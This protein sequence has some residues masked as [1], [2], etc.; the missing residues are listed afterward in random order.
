MG[1]TSQAPSVKNSNGKVRFAALDG[2]ADSKLEENIDD[3]GS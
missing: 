1:L 3:Q 2:S